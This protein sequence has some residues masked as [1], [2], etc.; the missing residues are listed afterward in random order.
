MDENEEAGVEEIA[1]SAPSGTEVETADSGA[2]AESQDSTDWKALYEKE[3]TQNES[4]KTAFAQKK[5]FVKA[6]ITQTVEEDDEETPLTKKD[7]KRLIREEVTPVLAENKVETA[8]N[9]IKDPEKRKL[10]KFYYENRIRQ[11]G[12]ND[13]A[14][15]NDLQ[16]AEA[17]A[18]GQKSKKVLAEV[19]RKQNMQNTPPM[20]GSSADNSPVQ[21]NHKFSADQVKALTATAQRIGADPTKF[22]ENAWKNQNKG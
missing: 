21:K 19:N 9:G 20:S 11:T 5:Q 3:H 15:K 2:S 10:V 4:L 7:F 13:D 1:Q 8:L 22:I 14:I 17:I 12:T 6:G 16:A 18:D